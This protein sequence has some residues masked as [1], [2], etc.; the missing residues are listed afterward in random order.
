MASPV[1]DDPFAR[2][3]HMKQISQ[4]RRVLLRDTSLSVLVQAGL[5]R[6]HPRR[7]CR[8]VVEKRRGSTEGAGGFPFHPVG[9]L[10]RDFCQ[11]RWV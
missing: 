6:E 9:R 8:L 7:R 11:M 3:L 4:T 5:Y 10:R 2:S 1:V